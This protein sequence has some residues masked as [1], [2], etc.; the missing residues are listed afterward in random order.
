MEKSEYEFN[1]WGLQL[2]ISFI[3]NVQLIL[4]YNIQV[5]H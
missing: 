3:V 4:V 1:E 2:T 5:H